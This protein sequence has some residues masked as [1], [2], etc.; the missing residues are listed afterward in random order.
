MPEPT[1]TISASS[2]NAGRMTRT[3][4]E[5]ENPDFVFTGNANMTRA[6][7][8]YVG[9]FNVSDQQHL[10]ER[11]WVNYNPAQ[12]GKILVIPARQENERVS[13]PFLI[14][15][16]VQIPIRNVYSGEMDTRGQDGKFLAQDAI[17]PEDSRGSWRTVKPVNAG[18]AANE[19]TNLYNWG[20]FWEAVATQ[21]S[22]PSDE[23][24]TAAYRR[25]EENYNRL[26]EEAKMLWTAGGQGRAQIGNT[27]RRAASYFG[28]EFEWNQLYRQRIECEGCGE[29]I[30]PKAVICPT[31]GAVRDWQKAL[32]LGMKTPAQAEAAG[33]VLAQAQDMAKK[34]PKSS[35]AD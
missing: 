13:K 23:A 16:V 11:P 34:A 9:I 2:P 12:R 10:I 22:T 27:H 17:N 4:M 31:C 28:Q 30:N 5:R 15:D 14:S 33:I 19:G 25:L 20:V 3:M 29:K 7:E 8:F 6:P 24:V 18:L 35:R 32:A 1:A 26:I 21:T